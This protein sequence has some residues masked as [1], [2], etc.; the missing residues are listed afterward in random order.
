MMQGRSRSARIVTLAVVAIIVAACG[1]APSTGAPG[2]SVGAA[3]AGPSLTAAPR[4][5]PTMAPF[6]SPTAA[7]TSSPSTAAA[8]AEPTSAPE[9]TAKSVK[10]NRP[11]VIDWDPASIR[12][13]DHPTERFDGS[14]ANG[15]TW[16]IAGSRRRILPDGDYDERGAI[17]RSEGGS[18]WDLVLELQDGFVTAIAANG[19]GFVAVGAMKSVDRAAVWSSRDGR[20]WQPVD[21]AAFD[22]GVMREVGVTASGIVAFG[23][24]GGY[25]DDSKA[26]IWTSPDGISWLRATN[27]SGLRVAAGLEA[28][29][30]DPGRLTAFVRSSD[31]EADAIEVWTT[32][33]RA[34]WQKVGVLPRSSE[35]VVTNAAHGLQGWVAAGNSGGFGPGVAWR[36]TD[37]VT[38]HRVDGGPDTAVALLA[39]GSG[40]VATGYVGSLFG[41]TCGDPRPF[42]AETWTSTDGRVWHKMPN[43]DSFGEAAITALFRHDRTLT[44][45]GLRQG[46]DMQEPEAVAWEAALP[47]LSKDDSGPGKPSAVAHGCGP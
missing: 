1:T 33:G 6:R 46:E 40:F 35:T 26:A 30:Q 22:G 7:P 10:A 9:P 44:G 36:S 45:V 18:R 41:E 12:G 34:E 14:A 37:G 23:E 42:Q 19:P 47:V 13:L 4:R 39:D 15:S 16:L 21:D 5:S 29:V 20:S 3:T 31:A 27:T 11:L 2:P 25:T 17:W 8:T 24:V 38:W 43:K 32:T 28:L